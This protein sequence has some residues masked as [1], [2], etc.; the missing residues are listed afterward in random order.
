[1]KSMTGMGRARGPILQS[2]YIVEIKSVNHRYCEVFVRLPNRLQSLE[3]LIVQS[4]KKRISRGKI[5]VWIGEEKS[6][7][8]TLPFNEKA[9]QAYF[10]FL[11]KIRKKYKL[12]E[13]ISLSHLLGGSTFW[14]G[15]SEEAEKLKPGVKKLIDLALDD[16]I[17]MRT[18][19][20]QH[21]AKDLEGHV[22]ILEKLQGQVG[23]KKEDVVNAYQAKL[24]VRIE[25]LLADVQVDQDKLANEL[26]FF[27]DRCDINEELER[28]TSHFSK[29]REIM[30][31]S[32]PCG[33]PLDFLI[34]EMNREWNTI[35]SKSA[36]PILAHLIVEAKSQM[37]KMREQVQNIE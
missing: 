21:L 17:S 37:E 20:G 32:E 27:A 22:K 8:T 35:G 23:S 30:K 36:D 19:E 6:E 13:E 25:K 12:K 5:D 34:Q 9:L 14:T 1:M 16:L 7:D 2:H 15:R 18:K 31:G 33:R 29:V 24:K 26:A 4:V 28:L 11:E 10:V 3:H